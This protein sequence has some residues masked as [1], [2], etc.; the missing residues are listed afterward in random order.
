MPSDES[1]SQLVQELNSE[2]ETAVRRSRKNLQK[3]IER[4]R[5][6][7]LPLPATKVGQR[8][9]Q[10]S[11]PE[12]PRCSKPIYGG[13]PGA[14]RTGAF[15]CYY[16]VLQA[17]MRLHIRT[18]F[19]PVIEKARR[20]PPSSPLNLGLRLALHDAP[21]SITSSD[22]EHQD[23]LGA[24]CNSFGLP[25][26]TAAVDGHFQQMCSEEWESLFSMTA[27]LEERPA[28]EIDWT[29]GDDFTKAVVDQSLTLDKAAKGELDPTPW[30]GIVRNAIEAEK[31]M[32][33]ALAAGITKAQQRASSEKS[34]VPDVRQ[35]LPPVASRE[36][37]T[38]PPAPK[39]PA[40]AERP[41]AE[42]ERREPERGIAA[43]DD[44][45]AQSRRV[46]LWNRVLRN[47]NMRVKDVMTVYKISEGTVYNWL[48]DGKLKRLS[49]KRG[50]ISAASMKANPPDLNDGPAVRRG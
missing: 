30:V 8:V 29:A 12:D 42:I 16:E 26:L 10:I 38:D 48:R 3:E 24:L 41:K 9:L 21:R 22:S 28:T 4:V 17:R 20:H 40:R 33:T 27:E 35:K 39:I 7:A 49:A 37:A 45:G 2:F 25:D 34:S 36:K 5:D 15:W 50:F 6:R 19:K 14:L 46:D 43:P 13:N 31:H 11:D 44:Q 18:N 1:K 23:S 47:E 32:M